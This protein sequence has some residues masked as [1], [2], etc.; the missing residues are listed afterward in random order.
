[1]HKPAEKEFTTN[2]LAPLNSQGLHLVN[3]M[4]GPLKGQSCGKSLD[5]KIIITPRLILTA[6]TKPVM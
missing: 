4:D 3:Y 2:V 1:M 6:L 5:S